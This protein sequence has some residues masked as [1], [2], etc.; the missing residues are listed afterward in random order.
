MPDTQ[1]DAVVRPLGP[2]EV[3]SRAFP[4]TRRGF[5]PE[6][7]R[8]FVE[9]VAVAL[10]ASVDREGELARRLD[11]AERRAAAPELDEETLTAAVGTETAKVLRAAHD[12]AREVVARA[13]AR[14]GEILAQ[15]GSVLTERRRE[16]EQEAARIRERA[17]SEA[18]ALTESTTAQCRS[19]VE[20]AREARRRIL[21]DLAERRRALHVQLEQLRAGKDA[22]AEVVEETAKTV[23]A[24]R[25]RLASSEETARAAADSAGYVAGYG[26]DLASLESLVEEAGSLRGA[27]VLDGS[28]SVDAD[29]V[30]ASDA[31]AV[32]A[33]P[34]LDRVEES[35]ESAELAATA[36]HDSTLQLDDATADESADGDDELELARVDD[37]VFV[38]RARADRVLDD[39]ALAD[40]SG[41]RDADDGGSGQPAGVSGPHDVMDDLFAR[42]RAATSVEPARRVEEIVPEPG[43]ARPG[44]GV[45]AATEERAAET[46]AVTEDAETTKIAGARADDTLDAEVDVAMLLARRDELLGAVIGDLARIVKRELRSEQN[47][48]LDSLRSR[49]GPGSGVPLGVGDESAVRLATATTGAL[50]AA[51]RAGVSFCTGIG[52]ATVQP[53]PQPAMVAAELADEVVTSLRRR[54]DD[55]LRDAGGD[56]ATAELVGAAYRQWRGDRVEV[57]VTDHA[58]AAFSLGVLA[59]LGEHAGVS[60]AVDGGDAHCPDC[61]DNVLSGPQRA[62]EPFPTGHAHPPA[63]SGC[64]CL[65]VPI[66]S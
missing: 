4:T 18:G 16:A 29:S 59:C 64:R 7:V 61:D 48:L 6:A 37:D 35:A 19:M 43:A 31:D 11:D 27:G 28:E 21:A 8:R 39:H 30:V 3:R 58:T 2:A 33:S 23:E 34:Q 40:D 38:D 54:L 66:G 65:L 32:V 60:W 47:E 44:V 24:V 63:H 36:A 5:D 14:A 10:Q 26:R 55:A 41:T 9:E 42:L 17:R 49:R 53:G 57:L 50:V 20:E 1:L 25:A 22:L 15:A 62:G 13:E 56:D 45:V 46:P 51:W 52:D 12:A